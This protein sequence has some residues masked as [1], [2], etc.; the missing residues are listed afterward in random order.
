MSWWQTQPVYPSF[1]TSEWSPIGNIPKY[2]PDLNYT[3]YTFNIKYI[4]ELL[5]FI[6]NNYITGYK[7]TKNYLYRKITLNNSISLVLMEKTVIVGFIYSCPIYINNYECGYVDLMTVAKYK[8]KNGLAKILI[9]AITN[10]S[11]KKHYIHKKDNNP[12]PF[13]FFYNTKHYT[14]NINLN[15]KTHK[16]TLIESNNSNITKVYNI[17]KRW[18]KTQSIQPMVDL[19]TFMS[20]ESIKTYFINDFIVSVAIFE[21]TY[22][23]IRNTKIAELFFINYNTF[24]YEL[25]QSLL[26]KLKLLDV[27]FLVVQD[28]LFFRDII[29]IDN[30]FESMDLYLHSYNLFIPNRFNNIQIPVF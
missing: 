26:F 24:N 12:L 13:P 30:F 14:A 15:Y 2:I 18:V 6:N 16:Y 22:G 29:K 10:Y 25:Y 1:D 19:N 5:T 27:H 28:N 9:S 17:Y 20:S 4:D 21:F 8:R 23:L 7:I 11:N 3:I